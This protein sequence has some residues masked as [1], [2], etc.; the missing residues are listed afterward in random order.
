M[1][2]PFT[3]E[4]WCVREP[5]PRLDVLAEIETAFTLA[6]GCLGIRGTFDEGEPHGMP[7]TYLAGLYELRT[8]VY[9]ETGCGDPEATQTL[10]N[11]IDGSQ[12]RLSVDGQPFDMRA[13]E[14]PEHERV[15]DMRTGGPRP[16]GRSTCGRSGWCRSSTGGWR[17]SATP[18]PPWTSPSRS[19]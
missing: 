2:D 14:L 17:R 8:M 7:G 5:R 11:T 4:Q 16:V 15:L 6:N 18:S 3:V 19:P 1:S 13:G 10:V 12:I 9:T